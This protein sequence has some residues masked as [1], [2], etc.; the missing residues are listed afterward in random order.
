[1]SVLMPC[2]TASEGSLGV[3]RHLPVL[4]CPV[5]S[6][7]RTK[8]VKV[9]P[10]SQPRRKYF[11]SMQAS[12]FAITGAS[13]APSTGKAGWSLPLKDSLRSLLRLARVASDPLR[14][15]PDRQ[16]RDPRCALPR[17]PPHKKD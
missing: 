16:S 12:P 6:S 3:V 1:S 5:L 8:S 9:P 4:I 15:Y 2:S 17:P 10:M 7:S 13:V 14:G 11:S